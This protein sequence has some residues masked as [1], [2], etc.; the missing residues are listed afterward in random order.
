MSGNYVIP[1][2][3]FV[4]RMTFVVI[5]FVITPF[6]AMEFVVITCFA[7]GEMAFGDLAQCLQ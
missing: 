3:T 6:G 5:E 7:F 1:R 4:P 2:I